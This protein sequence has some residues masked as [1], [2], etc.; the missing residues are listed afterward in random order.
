M[1]SDPLIAAATAVRLHAY[2]PY[3]KFSV[4]AALESETGEIFLGCNVEN[5]S[6]GLTICAERGALQAAITAGHRRFRRI[7]IVSDSQIPVTP[8]GACRQCL[9]EFKE[10]L[11]VI[12][13]NLSGE[14]YE[15]DLQR[16]LPRAK[17]G[18]LG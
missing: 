5:I 1:N 4:G 8:C 2:A 3:S 10:D 18:I 17:A 7:V 6:F 9:A 15:S 12:S 14:V 11:Q 13:A 16:L